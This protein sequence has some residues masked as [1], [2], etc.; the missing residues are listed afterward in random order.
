MRHQAFGRVALAIGVVALACSSAFA[1]TAQAPVRMRIQTAVPSASIYFELLRK[2][3]RFVAAVAPHNQH[4]Q[5]TQERDQHL[6]RFEARPGPLQ[7]FEQQQ[8]RSADPGAH[9]SDDRRQ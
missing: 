3:G 2:M 9:L 7:V 4:V 8:R 1:Q 5:I 6:E